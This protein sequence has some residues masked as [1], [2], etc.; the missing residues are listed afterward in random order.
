MEET[1]RKRSSDDTDD[2]VDRVKRQRT[3]TI[4]AETDRTLIATQ[5]PVY[6][7]VN[8]P[9]S[10]DLGRDGLRRSIAL[11]LQHVGFD[12]ATHEALESFTEAVD[13]CEWD[14][15]G[16]QSITSISHGLH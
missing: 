16:L 8:R 10:E 14:L 9:T 7:A 2:Q 5:K 15:A 12:S 4:E 13:T 6:D 3:E 11:V 1:S